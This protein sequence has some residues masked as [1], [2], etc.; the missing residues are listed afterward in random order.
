MIQWC[1]ARRAVCGVLWA[2]LAAVA[3]GQTKAQDIQTHYSQFSP[4]DFTLSHSP[5]AFLA[6]YQKNYRV[7]RQMQQ[8]SN[9]AD[10][11]FYRD[12]PRT[13]SPVLVD[14]NVVNHAY[15]AIAA[16]R[17][18]Y[19]ELYERHLEVALQRIRRHYGFSGALALKKFGEILGAT[20]HASNQVLLS[21]FCRWAVTDFCTSAQLNQ[22]FSGPGPRQ[23]FFQSYR[24][25]SGNPLRLEF[26]RSANMTNLVEFGI[27]VADPTTASPQAILFANSF[28]EQMEDPIV[29][30]WY[31]QYYL[32][33]YVQVPDRS[34]AAGAPAPPV[35]TQPS[36]PDLVPVYG[37]RD[38]INV[39][40]A[41]FFVIDPI[42]QEK[43]LWRQYVE[44]LY[45]GLQHLT[46]W[47]RIPD[48]EYFLYPRNRTIGVGANPRPN[49]VIDRTRP[50]WENLVGFSISMSPSGTKVDVEPSY[51]F[52]NFWAK[53][54]KPDFEVLRF[55]A[56]FNSQSGLDIDGQVR[57]FH[58][59]SNSVGFQTQFE[60]AFRKHHDSID[61]GDLP[62][63]IDRQDR[64]FD[65]TA[66]EGITE[67]GTCLED[68][69]AREFQLDF[70]PVLRWRN[71]QFAIMES[72]RW[73]NR[74]GWDQT[75]SVGQF[76]FNVNYIFGRGQVG[77]Y[78]TRANRDESVVRSVN[79]DDVFFEETFLKVTDQIG[80][81]FDLQVFGNY[82]V[83]GA[84]GWLD[85]ALRDGAPG[86]VVRFH[87][88]PF[89]RLKPYAEF[90]INESFV[91]A[92][93]SY[94]F[95]FGVRFGKWG[96]GDSPRTYLRAPGPVPVFVPRVRYETL[97]RTVRDGNRPPLAVIKD[98]QEP[99]IVAAD[100]RV[101][102]DGSM[103][104]DPD[105]DPITYEWTKLD[106]CPRELVL[107]NADGTGPVTEDSS[108][109]SFVIGPGQM[110]TVQLVVTDSFGARSNPATKKVSAEAT[111]IPQIITFNA[112]PAEIRQGDTSKLSWETV[113]ASTVTIT[114][115]SDFVSVTDENGMD[116]PLGNPLPTTGMA[117]TQ[118]PVSR[119]YVI[120][121]CNSA[122]QCV[123]AQATVT[124]LAPEPP[125]ILEFT[126]SPPETRIGVPVPGVECGPDEAGSLL[127]WRTNIDPVD[128]PGDVT[129][130]NPEGSNPVSPSASRSVCLTQTTA[131]TLTATND[132]G[133]SNSASVTVTVVPDLPEVLEFI[134]MPAQIREGDSSLLSWRT[135]GVIEVFISNIPGDPSLSPNG[136]VTVRP[137]ETTTYDFVA[138]NERGDEASAQVTV[139]VLPPLPVIVSFVANPPEIRVGGE[140]STS[141][142]TWVTQNATSVSITNLPPLA[143][144]G[145]IVVM[146]GQT[147]T[148]TLTATN[149]AGEIVSAEVTLL[150]R[151]P[152]PQILTFTATPTFANI[153]LPG[154]PDCG[155]TQAGST[156]RWTTSDAVTVTL[157]NSNGGSQDVEVN[158]PEGFQVCIIQTTT[159]T[160]TVSNDA[161]EI[162]S[163]SVTVTVG[164]P[165]SPP[166][167]IEEFEVPGFVVTPG[168]A[169]IQWRT[170]NAD[171][172]ML[173]KIT[174]PA[175]NPTVEILS[176]SDPQGMI[177]VPISVRT[178][179]RLTAFGE[180]GQ[181]VFEEKTIL[182]Q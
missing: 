149:G 96:R 178:I 130:T 166:P 45:R 41:D 88:P 28:H 100:S 70:G 62:R 108:S 126:A 171:R 141:T 139:E 19:D 33:Q 162:V 56:G 66:C 74:S 92:E 46:L 61:L 30:H 48:G 136:T 113:G 37:Q 168:T 29:T 175:D 39:D 21:E 117:V 17:L 64:L 14:L 116:V 112:D 76:F 173:E 169:T 52:Q 69:S 167:V 150:V 157:T 145:S 24:D 68:F 128:N 101:V 1:L 87:M 163:A 115:A 121:A 144:N 86:G 6:E 129:L 27:R 123:T 170:S 73:I 95:G 81:N 146:P 153:G 125:L 179:I 57:L 2:F 85:L 83:E 155:E 44:N 93:D 25:A 131:F 32:N 59:F 82:R 4:I 140:P 22:L 49:L 91:A 182:G 43:L 110:C 89:W 23:S 13:V 79:F 98:N 148:Y 105:D 53:L 132:Q 20:S 99:M 122:N 78:L 35:S 55:G 8:A 84:F 47:A 77:G 160:L 133:E 111:P 36:P 10:E 63:F 109:I 15:M 138:R 18:G 72:L 40:S 156:L 90:G 119:T 67:D 152:L 26:D 11:L 114:N 142:L 181:S 143:V 80:V 159:F 94:R 7:V 75:G 3:C 65:P 5:A 147:T 107:E 16:A 177:D 158:R 127:E 124:V 134:A 151:P 161:G 103:S 31:L 38:R 12:Y 135:R 50:G 118:P 137:I 60:F 9:R 106:D 176:A 104:S 58:R 164:P 165:P 154:P 172:V 54:F 42:D 97:T 180:D 71:L 174:G 120:T 102:V 34:S 51:L